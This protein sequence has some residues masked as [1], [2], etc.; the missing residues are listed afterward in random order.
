MYSCHLSH[1]VII[2]LSE[3]FLLALLYVVMNLI[4]AGLYYVKCE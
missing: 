1:C 3:V 4:D 2:R